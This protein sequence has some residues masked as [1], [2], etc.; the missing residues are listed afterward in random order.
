MN[1]RL[2]TQILLTED[3]DAAIVSSS[4]PIASSLAT[5][6]VGIVYHNNPRIQHDMELLQ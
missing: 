4:S 2:G 6:E 3:V 1:C 5:H